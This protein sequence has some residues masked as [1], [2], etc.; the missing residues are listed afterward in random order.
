MIGMIGWL[1]VTPTVAGI[2]LGHWLDSFF[3]SGIFWTGTL[4]VLGVAFGCF[5]AWKRLSEEQSK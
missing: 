2:F 4:L 1:V 5:L 3:S